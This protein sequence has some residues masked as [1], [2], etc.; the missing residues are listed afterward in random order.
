MDGTVTCQIFPCH[1]LPLA[2]AR[3]ILAIM[4]FSYSRLAAFERCPFAYKKQWLEGVRVPPTP[5]MVLGTVLHGALE[6][7]YQSDL[8]TALHLKKPSLSRL[9]AC[10]ERAW[11]HESFPSREDADHCRGEIQKLLAQYHAAFVAGREFR[12]AWRLEQ[13][14]AVPCGSHT[15]R[16]YIDRI[17]KHNGQYTVVDYKSDSVLRTQ[18]EVDDDKQL[19]AYFLGCVRGLNIVPAA[20]QLVF[21]R[22]G[23]TV[24][25]TRYTRAGADGIADALSRAVDAMAS[26]TEFPPC[27]NRYCGSCVFA[28]EC[29]IDLSDLYRQPQGDAG[30]FSSP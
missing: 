29:G 8:F 2:A 25:C 6:E 5:A 11:R 21:L 1:S 15:L 17:D 22:F 23:V 14:I 3:A 19:A 24:T 9:L 27:R 10:G 7:F 26:A 16:G 28:S 30:A 18:A 4:N 13:F 12:P 20:M